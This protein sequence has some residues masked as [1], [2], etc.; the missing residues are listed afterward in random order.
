MKKTLLIACSILFI[1]FSAFSQKLVKTYYDPWK[2][3]KLKEK[4][5]VNGSNQKNGKYIKYDERGLVGVEINYVNGRPHGIAKEYY[6][7]GY[8]FPGDEKLK[9]EANYVNGKK[10]GIA[11]QHVYLTNGEEDLSDGKR[12]LFAQWQYDNDNIVH[13]QTW[14]YNGNKHYDIYKENGKCTYWYENG[15]KQSEFILKD[16]LQEGLRTEWYS[17]GNIMGEV[18][19][20]KGIENGEKTYYY[21]SGGKMKTETY[22]NGKLN[23]IAVDYAENGNKISECTYAN[24]ILIGS[25]KEWYDNGKPKFEGQFEKAKIPNSYPE[26]YTGMKQGIW[27]FYDLTGKPTK[28]EYKNDVKIGKWRMY[29]TS[30]WKETTQIDSAAYYR[31][32]TYTENGRIDTTQKVFDYYINGVKQFEGNLISVEPDVLDKECVFYY[33]DGNIE[34]SGAYDKGKNIGEWYEYHESGTL[35]YAYNFDKNGQLISKKTPEQLEEEGICAMN[36]SFNKKY[37]EFTDVFVREK[38]GLLSTTEYPIYVKDYPYGKI[39]YEKCNEL[40]DYYNDLYSQEKDAKKKNEIFETYE[41]TI[42]RIIELTNSDTKSIN[43]SLKKAKTI[44]EIKTTLS[45]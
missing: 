14:W 28:G 17:N 32:I 7:P 24:G 2:E 20:A 11:K 27:T 35:K 34:K 42:D 29:F 18:N 9:M 38:E 21:E 30:D 16:G 43:K 40:L 4:Y 5:Y 45:L 31:E 39:F 37:K 33:P 13:E 12:F 41:N 19:F 25:Y 3:T 1:S 6:L 10:H 15:T 22:A 44:E 36:S 23:G 8:G 26:R